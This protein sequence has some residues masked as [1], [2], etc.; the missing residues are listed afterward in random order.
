ML[1]SE[2][3]GRQLAHQCLWACSGEFETRLSVGA[4]GDN[5][6]LRGS[7]HCGRGF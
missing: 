1:N 7:Y 2:V 5:S 4:Y 3:K 6:G